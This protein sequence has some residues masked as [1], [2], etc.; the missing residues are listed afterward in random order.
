LLIGAPLCLIHPRLRRRLAPV[1]CS[2][3]VAL[4][5]MNL[6]DNRELRYAASLAP[7]VAIAAT[8]WVALLPTLHRRLVWGVVIVAALVFSAG[9]IPAAAQWWRPHSALVWKQD[10]VVSSG[11]TI[12][13]FEIPPQI[14]LG[15]VLW[16]PRFYVVS[17]LPRFMPYEDGD[18][19][20]GNPG[21]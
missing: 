4:V 14:G 11:R 6:S 10:R 19:P 18:L 17:P 12:T 1:A 5:L 16:P 13:D 2:G 7:F 20:F 3:L 21:P 8:A 15:D 9:W